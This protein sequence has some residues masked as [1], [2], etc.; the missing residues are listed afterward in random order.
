MDKSP[1][2]E[3]IPAEDLRQEAPDMARDQGGGAKRGLKLYA[4]AGEVP[5]EVK[6][7]PVKPGI[8]DQQAIDTMTKIGYTVSMT[9]GWTYHTDKPSPDGYVSGPLTRRPGP[10]REPKLEV[11]VLEYDG[12][13]MI[14]VDEAMREE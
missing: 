13:E 4:P 7:E 9:P 2:H 11:N 1:Y 3:V 14:P 12:R 5:A 8:V 10:K 6:Q